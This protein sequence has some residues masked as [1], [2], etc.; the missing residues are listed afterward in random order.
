MAFSTPLIPMT[1]VN[2]L[3]QKPLPP[4]KCFLSLHADN[5][6]LTG[7]KKSEDGESIVLRA[8]EI[9]GKMAESPIVFLGEERSFRETNLLEE[10]LPTGVQKVLHIQ[11]YEIDTLKLTH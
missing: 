10:N 5:L 11:P 6:V 8:F 1:S 7:L 3:S 9:E 2:A 4:E